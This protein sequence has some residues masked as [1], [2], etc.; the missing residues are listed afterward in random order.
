MVTSRSR[1]LIAAAVVAAVAALGLTTAA[2]A[3]R[4][5]IEAAGGPT[6]RRAAAGTNGP[7]L[8]AMT[9]EA[10]VGLRVARGLRLR[11]ALGT[12]VGGATE[13][14]A[15]GAPCDP[16]GFCPGGGRLGTVVPGEM[17]H[18]RAGIA[19]TVPGA[20]DRFEARAG[21]GAHTASV[22]GPDT[23][24]GIDAGVSAAITRW[25]RVG[26]D[27]TRFTTDLGLL[28]WMVSPS[29]QLRLRSGR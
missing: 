9:L 23:V 24:F 1:S 5:Q 19:W 14:I 7:G 6:W 22:S 2:G 3:Q 26:V 17:Y 18:G 27:A 20:G 11:A 13:F 12:T 15:I 8:D 21:A 28:R 16:S 25:L 4:L 29:I 10:G